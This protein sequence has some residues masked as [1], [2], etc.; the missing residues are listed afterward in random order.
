[1][2]VIATPGKPLT[3]KPA[4]SQV[5]IVRIRVTGKIVD[6]GLAKPYDHT[7]HPTEFPSI[8]FHS[9]RCALTRNLSSR[10]SASAIAVTTSVPGIRTGNVTRACPRNVRLWPNGTAPIR[11]T[12]LVRGNGLQGGFLIRSDKVYIHEGPTRG[13][14][15]GTLSCIEIASDTQADD[16]NRFLLT[17]GREA[18][19]SYVGTAVQHGKV[20]VTVETAA[21]PTGLLVGRTH[22]AYDPVERRYDWLRDVL[23]DWATTSVP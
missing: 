4:S 13:G 9:M 22:W 19:V 17:V 16:W 8:A 14:E 7:S 20:L 10:R 11:R 15:A 18:G 23:K 5:R 1:M 21:F 2:S 3:R 12:A 6:V